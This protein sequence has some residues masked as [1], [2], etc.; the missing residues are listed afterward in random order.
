MQ[1]TMSDQKAVIKDTDMSE[2]MQQEAIDCAI[3]ALEK[4]N[5]EKEIAALIK[6]EFEKKYSPTWHCIVGRKFG[7][8]V[9][10]ET[11]HFIF[12]LVRGVNIL[13]FKAG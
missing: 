11:K 9:S 10:H 1:V 12:F 2:D 13:L 7:S 4:Y 3:L 8:Y 5:V 6:R